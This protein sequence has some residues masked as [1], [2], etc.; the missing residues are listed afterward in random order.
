MA[1]WMVSKGAQHLVL[2]SRSGTVHGAAAK[3]IDDLRALGGNI[4]VCSCDVS[5][6]TAVEDLVHNGLASLPPIRGVIHGA[7]VLDDV[8]FESMTHAQYTSVVTSK[9]HG[10]R[11]FHAALSS[12]NPSSPRPSTSS[13]SELDFFI[14]ISSAAGAVGNRGQAANAAANTFLNGF[15]Q[16]LR[17]QNINACSLDL[18]AVSDAGYLAADKA[19]AA[20][21]MRNL[22]S[23][24]ICLSQVLAL[25]HAGIAGNLGSCN[26]HPITGMRIGVEKGGRPFWQHDAKFTHLVSAADASHTLSSGEGETITI[27]WSTKFR[28]A[29]SRDEAKDIVT[30]A[31]VEKIADVVSMD[32]SELDVE[33]NISAYP[34]DS[35][36]AI[37]VRNFITR[38]FESNLQVLE[39]LASGSIKTLAGVVVGKT[40]VVL[41]S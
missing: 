30:A 25:V 35:L 19:K 24:T 7:M 1:A 33:R 40:K 14:L 22:G 36:T 16:H 27:P 5:N 18:T 10:A 28:A 23:D 41:P 32:P 13:I 12:P 34:L 31:L 8:L 9:L 37:E 39:L 11:N 3:E 17:T 21:V 6:L 26:G 4:V 20:E 38:M 15:A 2:L 29:A